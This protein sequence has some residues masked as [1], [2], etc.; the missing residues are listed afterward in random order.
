MLVYMHKNVVSDARILREL[1]DHWADVDADLRETFTPT[2]NAAADR[3]ATTIH[4]NPDLFQRMAN[5]HPV[6][7]VP[8]TTLRPDMPLAYDSDAKSL[9]LPQGYDPVTYIQEYWPAHTQH[10]ASVAGFSDNDAL[11]DRS[12]GIEN[13]GK[14]LAEIHTGQADIGPHEWDLYQ[15]AHE[16]E[17]RRGF[18]GLGSLA[19]KYGR[20]KY[21][22]NAFTRI[23]REM[24]SQHLPFRYPTSLYTHTS[25]EHTLSNQIR[26]PLDPKGDRIISEKILRSA[27]FII[28]HLQHDDLLIDDLRKIAAAK[29]QLIRD[30]MFRSNDIPY[31]PLRSVRNGLKESIGMAIAPLAAELVR[32]SEAQFSEI[33]KGRWMERTAHK[34]PLGYVGPVANQGV[35]LGSTSLI[36][37]NNGLQFSS[38]VTATFGAMQAYWRREFHYPAL[39]AVKQDTA[40]KKGVRTGLY[41]PFTR[42]TIAEKGILQSTIAAFSHVLLEATTMLELQDNMYT[43]GATNPYRPWDVPH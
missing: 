31:D 40:T 29:E 24:I 41:C 3:V 9:L 25:S 22:E 23:E 37:S 27:A 39:E 16:Q 6:C 10:N 5:F 13:I 7:E 21:E 33:I 35:G 12:D 2:F 42:S 20:R 30:H 11:Q 38:D 26:M 8:Y 43:F 18:C 14:D 34:S 4:N 36:A 1:H 28:D 32:T 15:Q 17:H 19:A